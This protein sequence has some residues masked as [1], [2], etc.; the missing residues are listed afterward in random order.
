MK[1]E[2]MIE[3]LAKC[4]GAITVRNKF[5]KNTTFRSKCGNRC[6]YLTSH[7]ALQ[8]IIDGLSKEDGDNYHHELIAI[9]IRD[10]GQYSWIDIHKATCEQKA[11]AILKAL[12]LWEGE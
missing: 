12:K 7:D 8:R 3:A 1:K 5:N 10:G 2:A 4:E 6:N 11:E 9:I